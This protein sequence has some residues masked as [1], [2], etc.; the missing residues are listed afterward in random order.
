[1]CCIVGITSR[2]L[3]ICVLASLVRLVVRWLGLVAMNDTG[4]MSLYSVGD[5]IA[6]RWP[7]FPPPPT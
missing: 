3:H 7:W 2:L 6:L 4:M 5:M 1:V